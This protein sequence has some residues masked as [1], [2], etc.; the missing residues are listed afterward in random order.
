MQFQENK[1]AEQIGNRT[2][3]AFVALNDDKKQQ[4]KGQS[5]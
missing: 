3:L 4:R 1:W 2:M 5:L